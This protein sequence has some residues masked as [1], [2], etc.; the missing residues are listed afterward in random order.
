MVE[1]IEE[2]DESGKTIAL[3]PK[4]EL[5]KRSFLHK[6]SFII[7][8]HEGK[9]LLARRAKDKYP[10]PDVWCCAVG[11]KAFPGEDA[12]TT[13]LR[14]MKEEIGI[15]VPLHKIAEGAFNDPKWKTFFC[16]FT[17]AKPFSL[18]T[19]KINPK[20][21]QYTKLFVRED[22]KGLMQKGPEQFSPTSLHLLKIFVDLEQ[23]K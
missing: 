5:K 21:I 11:G 23:T 22:L 15:E 12:L 13:A 4:E 17:N 19:I 6:A 3:H 16:L 9:I 1:Y 20:E 18:E 10:F 7:P 14:E 2:V 8:I